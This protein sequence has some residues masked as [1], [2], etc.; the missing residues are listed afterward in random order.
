MGGSETLPRVARPRR[1][2]AEAAAGG[3]WDDV[4]AWAG[5][6]SHHDDMTLLVLRLT[7]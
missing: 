4:T 6:E 2:L 5:E 3:M 7:R 1:Q